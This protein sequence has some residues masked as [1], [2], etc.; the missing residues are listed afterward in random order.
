MKSILFSFVSLALV[1]RNAISCPFTPEDT[2]NDTKLL[3]FALTL[4]HLE[5]AFYTD[6]LAK[7][8][9][10]AF[11]DAG[12]PSWVRTRFQQIADHEASH[13]ALLSNTLG[14]KAVQP[15]QYNFPYSDPQSFVAL[16]MV[17]E[18]LGVSA[19]L[20]AA[21]SISN[22]DLLA[23]AASIMTIEAR[24]NAWVAS[25]VRKGAAWGGS[26][27]V[28]LATNQVYSIAASFISSCPDANSNAIQMQ[29]FPPLHIEN[30][31]YEPGQ[32]IDLTYTPDP[33]AVPTS[34]SNNPDDS[35]ST[36]E[37]DPAAGSEDAPHY[38]AIYAG[39]DPIFV[40]IC[41][42]QAELPL[43][44]GGTGIVYAVVTTSTQSVTDA[45]TIAGPALLYFPELI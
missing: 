17:L 35:G 31:S 2:S 26:L 29:S 38:L 6:G 32:T 23:V 40:E 43:N 3:N 21:K 19:Y 8:D 22:P 45:N 34:T 11:K 10:H 13:V 18:D 14:D 4:E 39:L 25:A 5:Y 41:D 15:C 37:D 7:Y 30:C 28:A 27:D 33:N 44:L 1:A 36:A 12:F 9:Q 42:N 20:G 24:H 16:S